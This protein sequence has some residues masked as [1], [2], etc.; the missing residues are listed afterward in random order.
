MRGM[1]CGHP[2]GTGE[3]SEALGTS[4]NGEGGRGGG[5]R[6]QPAGTWELLAPSWSEV[7]QLPHNTLVR[8][9]RWDRTWPPVAALGPS[10]HRQGAG[11]AWREAG[12]SQEPPWPGFIYEYRPLLY[13]PP[14]NSCTLVTTAPPYLPLPPGALPLLWEQTLQSLSLEAPIPWEN[15]PVGMGALKQGA[16]AVSPLPRHQCGTCC[17]FQT[18]DRCPDLRHPWSQYLPLVCLWL[19]TGGYFSAAGSLLQC[20]SHLLLCFPEARTWLENA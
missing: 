16:G 10:V 18:R 3:P 19:R 5:R 12:G 14:I 15:S 1:L 13:A 4:A 9:S 7:R 11:G 8:P 6:P 2:R 17:W 20:I